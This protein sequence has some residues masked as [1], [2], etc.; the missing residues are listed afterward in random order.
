MKSN[1][2][3]AVLIVSHGSKSPQARKEVER[4]A[5]RL[6]RETGFP[7]LEIAFLDVEPPTIG[8]GAEACVR[9]GASEITVLLNF[10]NSG[11][12]VLHDVPRVLEATRRR[13][14][15]VRWRTTPIIGGHPRITELYADLVKR[16]AK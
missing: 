6:K 15:A 13:F 16:R 14:P 9:K 11:N 5:R 2:R 8:E 3:K 12:H 7:I 4:L 1:A 10:L